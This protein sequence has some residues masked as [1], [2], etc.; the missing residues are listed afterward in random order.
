MRDRLHL[1][2]LDQADHRRAVGEEKF[3]LAG[4]HV[5]ERKPA[6][7]IGHVADLDAGLMPEHFERQMLQ[8]AVAG[9][10]HVDAVGRGLREGDDVGHGL[11]RQRRRHHQDVRHQRYERDRV[12]VLVVVERQIRIERRVDRERRGIVQHGV[13]VRIGFRDHR[14]ADGAAGPATVFD[15]ELLAEQF[16]EGA[17]DDAR[18]GVGAAGRRIGH[19][20]AHR[21]VRPGSLRAGRRAQQRHGRHSGQQ[22]APLRLI[23]GIVPPVSL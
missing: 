22:R 8:R 2:A 15:D 5:V 9:R 10:R 3:H 7:A 19:D 16:T 6:A 11:H 17:E 18:R 13:A 21:P 12:E 23:P 4:D 1:A 14:L 20:H